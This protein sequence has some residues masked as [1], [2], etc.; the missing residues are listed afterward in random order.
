LEDQ[1]YIQ[2]IEKKEH[3]IFAIFSQSKN[4]RIYNILCHS[5]GRGNRGGDFD[6]IP[7]NTSK[8]NSKLYDL[9]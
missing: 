1:S 8:Y 2:E 9:L 7:S 6:H 5:F 3:E 4:Q